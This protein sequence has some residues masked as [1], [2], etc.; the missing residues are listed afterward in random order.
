MEE[1]PQPFAF[2]HYEQAKLFYHLYGHG[3]D[4]DVLSF[5]TSLPLKRTTDEVLEF[6]K[7]KADQHLQY[8]KSV[9][10]HISEIMLF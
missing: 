8:V 7:P 10:E 4:I 3:D 9:D 5:Y 6:L 1:T 2:F